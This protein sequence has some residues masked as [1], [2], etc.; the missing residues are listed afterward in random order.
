MIN[1]I[2]AFVGVIGS[3]KDY[4]GKK[5]F[6]KEPDKSCIIGFSDGVRDYTWKLL[7]WK[8]ENQEEYDL[9]KRSIF[10][11]KL[12]R[13]KGL[14]GREILQK[15]G[16]D[17][18][19]EYDIN[20]WANVWTKKVLEMNNTQTISNIIVSDVRHPNEVGALFSICNKLNCK[21]TIQFTNFKSDRYEINDHES[22]EMAVAITKS[23][24]FS[25]GQEITGYLKES[26]VN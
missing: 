5:I 4:E 1:S 17:L 6:N 19:R 3:G 12:P 9:F 16:T 24:L 25:H 26:Y 21:V 7:G 13:F 18:M 15:V 22:E 20:V 10:T 23:G 14:T 11:C 8:P 2:H